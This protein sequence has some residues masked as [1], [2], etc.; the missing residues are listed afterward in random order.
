MI[1]TLQN[2]KCRHP[3][4]I[5]K[6]SSFSSVLQFQDPPWCLPPSQPPHTEDGGA[7]SPSSPI[8]HIGPKFGEPKR[9]QHVLSPL[10]L[11]IIKWIKKWF[12]FVFVM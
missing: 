8:H 3:R 9:W 1:Q 5:N 10:S 12:S 2:K 6:P 11:F 7:R 4:Q